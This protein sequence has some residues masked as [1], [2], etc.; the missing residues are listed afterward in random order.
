MNPD[1][2]EWLTIPQVSALAGDSNNTTRAWIPYLP[3][4][5]VRLT[6]GGQVRLRREAVDVILRNKSARSAEDSEI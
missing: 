5:H 3:T 6:P 1:L 2:K 4:D